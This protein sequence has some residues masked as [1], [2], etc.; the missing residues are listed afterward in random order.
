MKLIGT[1]NDFMNKVRISKTVMA[2]NQSGK[3]KRQ[4]VEFR[5]VFSE[6]I[7]LIPRLALRYLPVKL[8][9]CPLAC[10]CLPLQLARLLSCHGFGNAFTF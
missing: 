4:A 3:L 8:A 10:G 1:C 9:F 7:Q 2:L 5:L 6:E